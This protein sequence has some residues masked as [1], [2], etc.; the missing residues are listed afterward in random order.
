MEK[1]HGKHRIHGKEE[2][3]DDVHM[4]MLLTRYEHG[5]TPVRCDPGSCHLPQ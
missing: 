4:L 3:R 5:T 1:N 2:K